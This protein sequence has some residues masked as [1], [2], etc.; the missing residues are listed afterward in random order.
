MKTKNIFM[1]VAVL[2][3]TLAGCDYEPI[4]VTQCIELSGR[5]TEPLVLVNHITDSN[6]A[7]Y[8]VEGD[9]T[10][11][12]DVEVEPGVTILMKNGSEI[13]VRDGGSFKCVGTEEENITIRG[14]EI[15]TSGQWETIHFRTN[16]T[17]NRLEYTNI[18]GGGSG[19]TYDGMVYIGYTGYAN[20]DHCTINFSQSHGIKCQDWRSNLGGIANSDISF[21]DLYPIRIDAEQIH[22][23]ASTNT[24][25]GN[26]IDK[27]DVNGSQIGNPILIQKS[28][29]LPYHI[30]GTF[31]LASAVTVQPGTIIY[32]AGGAKIQVEG[33]GSLNCT[34]TQ[35]EKIRITGNN[36]TPG[37][38]ESIKILF[39]SSTQ[40]RFE[41]CILS[42]GGG[43]SS[44]EGIVTLTGTSAYCYIADSEIKGS[45]RYGV[46]NQGDSGTFE[47]GGGIVWSDNTLGNVGN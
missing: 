9:F 46:Q 36:Q 14:E 7:D 26:G 16:D 12:A 40:N 21:C 24:G 41:H 34:G 17:N 10:I 43:S 32:M 8:C 28:V 45:A 39:S 4:D 20:I 29:A 44:Y 35:D 15:L 13:D 19:Q 1:T 42:Y 6:I 23:I 25:A 3:I 5:Q 30:N 33:Q 18:S 22:N 2:A 37:D 27:I 38:W 47:D 11:L 31:S